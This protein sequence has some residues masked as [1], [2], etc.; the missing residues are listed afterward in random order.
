MRATLILASLIGFL[1]TFIII[2]RW[3]ARARKTDLTGMDMNKFD[4]RK[5]AELGGIP[6]LVGLLSGVLAYLAI[7]TFYFKSTDNV[8]EIFSL[9]TVVLIISFIG[10]VDDILG[11]KIGLRQRQKPVLCLLA[12]VPLMV[13]NA[14]Q[15]SISLPLIGSIDIGLVYPLLLVPIAISGASNG[16]NMLAGYNGL[17]A[18]MGIIILSTLGIATFNTSPW[19]ALIAFSAVASLLAFI[20]Y[21]RYPAKIFPGNMLTYTIGALIAT[22]AILGNIE[23]IAI[24]LFIPYILQFFLKARG[25]MQKESFAKPL[26]DNSLEMPYKKIYGLEHLTIYLL[27]KIKRKVYEKDIVFTLLLMEM[28]IALMI[29]FI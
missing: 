29:L 16:F 25:K 27:K 4:K 24:F 5:V 8:I 15:S 10:L 12:A 7:K 3:I 21:N 2:P 19:I 11:W 6:V 20:F 26:K 28:I 1:V 18:G 22:I 9:I 23:K 13:I 17:E 14:G